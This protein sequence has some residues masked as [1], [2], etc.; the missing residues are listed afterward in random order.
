MVLCKET[1]VAIEKFQT[2]VGIFILQTP[3]STSKVSTWTETGLMPFKY[4]IWLR[5]A[6]YYWRIVNRKQ[7][8]ILK[9]C[10]KALQEQGVDDPL[11]RQILEIEKKI[12]SPITGLKLKELKEKVIERAVIFVLDIKREHGS[13]KSHP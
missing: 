3:R 12:R 13:L 5:V 9:E 4:R 7:D 10:V 6:V 8:Q 2:D 11:M 1:V